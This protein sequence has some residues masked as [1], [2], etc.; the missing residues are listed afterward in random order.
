MSGPI[1]LLESRAWGKLQSSFDT[2]QSF[3]AGDAFD[4]VEMSIE[5]EITYEEIQ[6]HVGSLSLQGEI[7][8][9]RGGK[10]STSCYVRP[11]AAGTAPDLGFL[12][13][14]AMGTET[15]G[16]SDVTYTLN[17]AAPSGIQIY[18]HIS[19]DFFQCFGGGWI[20]EMEISVEG[21]K[22]PMLN[23]SGGFASYGELRQG[24]TVSGAH[25]ATD[26][27]ILL[28]SGHEW[29]VRPGVYVKF[30]AEDNGGAGYLTT[31][32]D[33]A[34]RLLSISPALANPLSGGEAITPVVP[35]QTLG[36]LPAPGL[37]CGLSLA[38][39]SIEFCK[40]S[41]KLAT[42]VKGLDKAAT[43]NRATRLHRSKRLVTGELEVYYLADSA[44]FLGR[45]WDPDTGYLA[46]IL[47]LGPD[48]A[49]KRLK[50][51]LDR[52]R[53][54]APKDEHSD[55]EATTSTMAFKARQAAAAGDELE[56]VWD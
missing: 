37:A 12:L 50:V 27:T 49:G 55:E 45:A 41:V 2:F 56:L 26:A 13:T 54:D 16:G 42:G 4:Y 44:P 23:F 8:G 15:D 28:T 39:T 32:L 53:F 38:A 11:N 21:G 51:N 31:G 30:G 1:G 48:T 5:P 40:A 29:L 6:S 17:D 33:Y 22:A 14:H 46:A 9:K 43:S 10:W 35:A 18:R 20:E 19:D 36:G 47:R 7:E 24:A 3:A 52:I 34:T 25:I